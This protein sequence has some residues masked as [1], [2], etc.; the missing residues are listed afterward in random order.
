V[1]PAAWWFSPG[2]PL[3]A[4]ALFLLGVYC[5]SRSKGSL[6]NERTVLERYGV[7]SREEL[8]NL[9]RDYRARCQTAEE[10]T[11][12]CR[13]VRTT[14]NDRMARRENTRTDL[15]DFVHTFAPQ[16][17]D[18]FGCSAALSRALSLDHELA[19][20]RDRVAE[21]LRRRGD[22]AAQ[23][24]QDFDTLELL[25][26]PERDPQT[27]DRLL[28]QTTARLEETDQQLN[29]A[30]GRQKAMGDPA[31]L[32]AR[33]EE[34]EGQLERRRQ[35]YDA[36]VLAAETLQEANTR[37]Q[38]RFSPELNK[39]AGTYL[40][41]LTGDRYACVTL[42]RELEGAAQ[43]KEDVLPHSALYLSRGTAD[44]LYLAVRLAIC[45]LCLE[46]K[47]PIVLDDALAAFDDDRLALAL[48]LLRELGQEQQVLLFTCQRRE[49]DALP[50]QEQ[51]F[52]GAL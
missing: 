10:A 28:A 40:A 50:Q 39:L 25:H 47:P 31:A 36:I 3:L 12:H 2:L 1:R 4:V 19:A 13:M 27:T 32:A 33:R 46:E 26:T 5:L 41:R 18:L 34:L 16:V 29:Q 23:G 30:L 37:L 42:N 44:Q 9:V 35:E 20:A 8:H 22:L 24:G 6:Q 21:R 49:Q 48:G 43:R 14:L 51:V 7:K 38:E 52:H 11:A 45:A 17:T 15:L